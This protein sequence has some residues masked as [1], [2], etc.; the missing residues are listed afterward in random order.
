MFGYD[1]RRKVHAIMTAV[2]GM[3]ILAASFVLPWW[4]MYFEYER[5]R[6]DTDETISY[7]DAGFGISV[8]S[9]ISWE[10]TGT[11][12]YIRN[13]V[14][15]IVCAIAAML[16]IMALVFASLMIA[17]LMV[18][19]L[20]RTV[21]SR[22]PM[23]FGMFAL[24]FCLLAPIVF[25]IALPI[26]MEADA[27]SEAS[28]DGDEY[29]VPDH[30]DPT[31]SFFGSHREED[32]GSSWVEVEETTWGG[33]IGWFLVFLSAAL[34]IVT[35]VILRQEKSPVAPVTQEVVEQPESQPQIGLKQNPPQP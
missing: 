9:G 17:G 16:V 18:D 2:A 10:D 32:T 33:D 20:R 21:K 7:S 8:S 35:V 23:M 25:M 29:E 13:S 15:T 11:S 34:F 1:D 26:A 24:F 19:L 31:K 12:L 3:V 28:L 14:T 22:I 30:D 6:L 27:R 4:G 5:I